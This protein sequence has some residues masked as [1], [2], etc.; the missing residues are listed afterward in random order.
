MVEC[1]VQRASDGVLVLAHDAE[2][3]DAHGRTY[4]I[5]EHTSTILHALDLG[6]GEG[7]PTLHELAAWAKGRCGV[8]A[9]M[10]CE[11]GDV[12]A[13]V[14]AALSELPPEEKI[15]PGAGSLSRQRFRVLDPTLP[16][17]FSM[18]VPHNH[19]LQDID[20]DA[21]M[22]AGN[23]DAVTWEYPLLDAARIA[24]LHARGLRVYAWT[25]D[26]LPAM[27]ALLDWGVDGIISNR[28]DLLQAL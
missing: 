24:D 10:K 28:A 2:V 8:M 26:D 5:A 19:P 12:E 20:L 14:V 17:S 16:L 21:L 15:V 23:M 11:G 9:D 13:K 18:G 7:V 6:A 3:T 27:R 1:D 25:V 22:A 4:P